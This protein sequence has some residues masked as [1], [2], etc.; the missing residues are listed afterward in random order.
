[1]R[2]VQF[3]IALAA[4]IAAPAAAGVSA[5][6]ANG[7][8]THDEAV[9]AA[10]PEDTWIALTDPAGWWSPQHSWSGNSAN[11][12]LYPVAGGCFCEE[13][14][15]SGGSVEHM[16]VIYADPDKLLR[17]SGALGPLQSEALTGTLTVTL[18]P[19]GSGTKISWDYVVGGFARIDLA[20]L[21]P[22]IDGVQSEQLGRL[23]DSLGRQ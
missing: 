10:S 21:A 14:P 12:T 4:V 6:G 17:L 3:S 2:P 1:M 13:L 15:E 16:R 9:V 8:A 11:F 18:E 7:L 20:A 19:A 5:T 22:V 23:A